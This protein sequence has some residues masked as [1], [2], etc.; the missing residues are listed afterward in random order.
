MNLARP[1]Y[2]PNTAD[3]IRRAQRG[4]HLFVAVFSS[5]L[6]GALVFGLHHELPFL[7]RWAGACSSA[8]YAYEC[9]SRMSYGIVAGA[10]AAVVFGALVV[11]LYRVAPIRPTLVCRG[12]RTW[13]WALDLEPSGGRC[14]RCG[15]DRFDYRAWVVTGGGQGA[16]LEKLRED[17]VAGIDLVRR[18][19]ETR[20][21]LWHRYY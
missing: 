18:F 5:V 2:D 8:A 9:P 4:T 17:D 12:C 16:G 3:T 7:A 6:V 21:S 20:R 13:G 1:L 10:C 11:L 19:R 14:P 15:G